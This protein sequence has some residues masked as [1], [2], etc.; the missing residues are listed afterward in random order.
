MKLPK[1][2]FRQGKYILPLLILVPL[3]AIIWLVADMMSGRGETVAETDGELAVGVPRPK[4]KAPGSKLAEMITR[5]GPGKKGPG[6]EDEYGADEGL[7]E[8]VDEEDAE[9]EE[10]PVYFSEPEEEPDDADLDELRRRLAD[11]DRASVDQGENNTVAGVQDDAPEVTQDVQTQ[12]G[13]SAVTGPESPETSSD[14]VG[15]A[16]AVAAVAV[17]PVD[18]T[19]F[20]TVGSVEGP[21][22][23][24]LIRA[25]VCETTKVRDGSRVKFELL[26]DIRV[27]D[28]LL[29]KGTFV[30]GRVRSFGAQRVNVEVESILAGD[31]FI[32]VRLSVY[33]TDGM[34]GFY[35]P[36]SDFRDFAQD[37][38]GRVAGQSVNI[39][40]QMSSGFDAGAFAMQAAQNAYNSLSGAVSRNIRRNKATIK[41]NTVIHLINTREL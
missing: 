21:A 11:L 16:P 14:A 6:A 30:Y 27:R 3:G 12:D 7:D 2:D 8:L 17:L 4:Q 5:F 28:V 39:N 18:A 13:Q 22:E 29:P 35:V 9:P 19:R 10:E 32:K 1:I 33:D 25:M 24:N 40:T 36:S 31:T 20:N 34:E 37:V 41:Y 26:D 15:E 38:G 23:R